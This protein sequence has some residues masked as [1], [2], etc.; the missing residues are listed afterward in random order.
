MARLAGGDQPESGLARLGGQAGG[1]GGGGGGGGAE[2][3]LSEFDLERVER[4]GGFFE[5]GGERG[6]QGGGRMVLAGGGR[7]RQ[8]CGWQP[9]GFEGV[10]DDFLAVGA[11]GFGDEDDFE[12]QAE[13]GLSGAEFLT[14]ETDPVG[15]ILFGGGIDAGGLVPP[16]EEDSAEGGGEAYA[17]PAFFFL[18]W[19]W[20]RGGV[21]GV[22]VISCSR[23]GSFGRRRG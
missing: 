17:Q 4:G 15:G 14:G 11:K 22:C 7:R 1:G 5:S 23:R 19:S 13:G 8:P 12:A 21:H 18:F 3:L 20:G 16:E 10:G 9:V 6:G 2:D